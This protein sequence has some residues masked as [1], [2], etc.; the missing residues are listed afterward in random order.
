VIPWK[1][2]VSATYR[3]DLL[4]L[5]Q[6]TVNAAP[7]EVSRKKLWKVRLHDRQPPDAL[8]VDCSF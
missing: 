8:V 5:R 4:L 3:L 1:T 2:S 6:S 7:E